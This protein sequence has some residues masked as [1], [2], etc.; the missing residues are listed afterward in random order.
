MLLWNYLA[1]VDRVVDGDT[2]DLF[3]D[4]GFLGYCRIR[5]RL[6]GIDTPET[7]GVKK[8]SEEYKAGVA[9]R[10]YVI[11][12]L[13]EHALVPG[14]HITENQWHVMIRSH[15]GKKI[16]SGKYGR[17]LVEVFPAD[18]APRDLFEGDAKSL[19]SLLVESGN[20]EYRT[21]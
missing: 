14:I 7:Y 13:N 21:Y 5:A 20:A 4:Q 17:W 10:E 11:A 9:A 16:D 8:E 19:N 18:V 2:L 15:D 3:V 12:W 1:R 6:Y